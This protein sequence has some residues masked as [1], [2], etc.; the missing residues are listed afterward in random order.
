MADQQHTQTRPEFTWLFLATPKHYPD[1]KPVVLRIDA[2]TEDEA[3]TAFCGWNMVFA[4]RICTGTRWR[5]TLYSDDNRLSATL[6][7]ELVEGV[8]HE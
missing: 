6:E 2:D 3:R 5:I 7:T 1:I 4:A 8:F